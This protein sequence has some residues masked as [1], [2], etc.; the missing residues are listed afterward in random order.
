MYD[1]QIVALLYTAHKIPG[2]LYLDTREGRYSDVRAPLSLL[3]KIKSPVR[4]ADRNGL[5]W[6]DGWKAPQ[7]CQLGCIS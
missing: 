4:A 6:S 1:G 3:D 7:S 5:Q 2:S